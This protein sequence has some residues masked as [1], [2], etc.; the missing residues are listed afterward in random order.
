MVR[1]LGRVDP[2]SAA[3]IMPRDQVRLL[4]ALE[5]YFATGIP[6]SRFKSADDDWLRHFRWIG[7]SLMPDREMLYGKIA[8]RVDAMLQQGWI[9]EVRRLLQTGADPGSKGFDAIGYREIIDH[10]GAEVAFPEL[11][12]RIAR[13][14]RNYAKRQMTW[15]RKEP[16]V[17]PLPGFG[18]DP[19]IVEQALARI[20]STWCNEMV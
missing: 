4:R 7:F 20:R 14:T 16:G 13:R 5:V 19:G 17:F 18:E 3:R 12:D 9:E 10:L 2:E 11:R 8:E 15:F 6:F 1:M